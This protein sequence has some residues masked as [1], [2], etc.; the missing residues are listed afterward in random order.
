MKIKQSQIDLERN[1]RK[2]EQWQR[3]A[4]NVANKKLLC[5]KDD[6]IQSLREMLIHRTAI[7]NEQQDLLKQVLS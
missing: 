3:H 4:E 1:N 5:E 2:M 6:R 7:I